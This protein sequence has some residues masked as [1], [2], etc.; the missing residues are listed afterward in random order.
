MR[1]LGENVATSALCSI[2]NGDHGAPLNAA[3]VA[4]WV[5]NGTF[6]QLTTA[7]RAEAQAR[8]ALASRFLTAGSFF[9]QAEGYHL[10]VPVPAGA[11]I[12]E[13]VSTLRQHT[14]SV[15]ASEAFAID[16]SIATAALR[17][18]IGGT[19]ARDRLERGLRLLGA[20]TD[21]DTTGRIS[22]V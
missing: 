20:L 14:L 21:A 3:V 6:Q 7:V 17:I 18:S 4:D 8:Q 5:A 16:P 11:N 10:W 22:I 2:V 12:G 19:I 9:A 1:R 15:V 13:I